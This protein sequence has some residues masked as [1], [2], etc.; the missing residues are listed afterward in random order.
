MI[1]KKNK[2]LFKEG[3]DSSTATELTKIIN[4]TVGSTGI[5][6][7]PTAIYN[8]F[9]NQINS[10]YIDDDEAKMMSSLAN[11]IL[12]LVKNLKVEEPTHLNR[13]NFWKNKLLPVVN[14]I[15]DI[16][17]YGTSGRIGAN[18]WK[19]APGSSFQRQIQ[20]NILNALSGIKIEI[21]NKFKESKQKQDEI[22]AAAA[23]KKAEEDKKRAEEAAAK[24]KQEEEAAAAAAAKKKSETERQGVNLSRLN[25]LCPGDKEAI[26]TLQ[27]WLKY[28]KNYK[29][30]KVDGVYG[31]KTHKAFMNFM[32]EGLLNQSKVPSLGELRVSKTL[33]PYL[34]SAKENYKNELT[35][36]NQNINY[37]QIETP[38]RNTAYEESPPNE[39]DLGDDTLEL[40]ESLDSNKL[41]M[42]ILKEMLGLS[43]NKSFKIKINIKG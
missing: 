14:Q 1:D 21:A 9:A 13:L 19:A 8:Y 38:A 11:N 2:S 18:T 20:R 39:V 25:I 30:L 28:V 26:P 5:E 42:Q 23:K 33:C 7:N 31:P 12:K 6:I 35:S 10:Y 16:M 29:Y 43:S 4:T 34:V 36:L 32:P 15:L 17:Q 37:G 3:V 22:S 40:E 24:A 27:Q 41:R